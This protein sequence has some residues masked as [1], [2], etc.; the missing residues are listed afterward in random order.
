MKQILVIVLTV[1][2]SSISFIASAQSEKIDESADIKKKELL[3]TEI[4]VRLFKGHQPSIKGYFEKSIKDDWAVYLSVFQTHGWTEFTTGPVYYI[5]P[6]M[7]VGVGVGTSRYIVGDDTTKSHH[8]TISAFW[9]LKSENWEAE[10]L[11]ESYKDDYDTPKYLEAY[12]Q[13]NVT[14]NLSFGFFAQNDI[15]WGPRFS[16]AVSKNVSIWA[17]PII[18]KYGELTTEA[19]EHVS[20]LSLFIFHFYFHMDSVISFRKYSVPQTYHNSNFLEQ[21]YYPISKHLQEKNQTLHIGRK[22][23]HPCNLNI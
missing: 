2:L 5:T 12:V 16:Y 11:A 4:E 23:D 6:E 7:S 21:I 14:D 8:A 18:K 10:I 9:F 22:D 15:G 13:K 1:M 19:R 20:M 17:S 3:D